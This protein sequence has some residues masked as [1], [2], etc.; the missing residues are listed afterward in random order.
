MKNKTLKETAN[1]LG[2][3]EEEFVSRCVDDGLLNP[4]GTPTAKGLELGIFEEEKVREEYHHLD[5]H[6][7]VK[8]LA[9]LPPEDLIKLINDVVVPALKTS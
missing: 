8:L 9:K 7:V 5:D 6:E 2:L 3:T 1:M 4:D